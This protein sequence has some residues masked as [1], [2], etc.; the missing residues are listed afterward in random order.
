MGYEQYCSQSQAIH[1]CHACP[2]ASSREFARLRSAGFIRKTYLA[3]IMA[4]PTLKSAWDAGVVSGDV[5]ILPRTSGSYDPGDPKELKGYGDQ[6]VAY[7]MREMKLVINDPDYVDNYTFYNEIGTRTDLVPFFR[8]SSLVHIFDTVAIIK[9]KDPVA[10]DIGAEVTW[11]VYCDII[12]DNLP[13]K[14]PIAT[15]LDVFT[16]PQA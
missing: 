16:C 4:D 1:V 15:I 7:G 2:T 13:S 8:T 12:S 10:D 6:K 9:A 11:E 3:T 14:H 5:I